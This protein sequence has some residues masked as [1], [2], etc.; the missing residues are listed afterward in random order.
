MGRMPKPTEILDA[1]GSFIKHPEYR[2][3]KEPAVAEPLGSAPTHLTPAQKKVWREL[4]KQL[5][6]GVA[7]QP[8]RIAFEMMA[9]LLCKFRAGTA[10]AAESAQLLNL[11]ARFGMTPSDRAKIHVDTPKKSGLAD[12]LSKRP[13]AAP[14]GPPSDDPETVQ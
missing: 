6:P 5:P 1:K 12:F 4:A 8:D 10:M 13:E 7:K 14:A 2:R 9:V 3:P 11:C